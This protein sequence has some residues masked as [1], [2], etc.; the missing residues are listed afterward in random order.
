VSGT[1]HSSCTFLEKKEFAL[2]PQKKK[3]WEF[4]QYRLSATVNAKVTLALASE[5]RYRKNSLLTTV[6]HGKDREPKRKSY[7]PG[8]SPAICLAHGSQSGR[9]IHRVSN[10]LA[11]S[12]RLFA[13]LNISRR[14]TARFAIRVTQLWIR[15]RWRNR[16]RLLL[17][18]EEAIVSAVSC[19]TERNEKW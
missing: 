11:R 12:R 16:S 2:L 4:L 19:S 5:R 1:R 15:R 13:D 8:Y 10:E 14:A 9:V 7:F 17:I 3:N 6:M 18:G